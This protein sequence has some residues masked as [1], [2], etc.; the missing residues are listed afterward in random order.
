MTEI[1]REE[2]PAERRPSIDWA[3]LI[4]RLSE[5]AP[6]EW[7]LAARDVPASSASN[8]MRR[9]R[10]DARVSGTNG[11]TSRAEKL[12]VRFVTGQSILTSACLKVRDRRDKARALRAQ[13]AAKQNPETTP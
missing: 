7:V 2:P 8:L 13:L 1:I 12:Y 10:V 5:E 4:L 6:D 9:Y 11:E 3:S